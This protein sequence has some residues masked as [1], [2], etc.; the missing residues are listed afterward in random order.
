MS[1]DSGGVIRENQYFNEP[2]YPRLTNFP[3][4]IDRLATLRVDDKKPFF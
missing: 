1:G 3:W 2:T 4:F